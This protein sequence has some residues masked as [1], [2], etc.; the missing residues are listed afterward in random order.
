MAKSGNWDHFRRHASRHVIRFSPCFQ[1]LFDFCEFIE[2]ANR[3]H[4]PLTKFEPGCLGATFSVC[5]QINPLKNDPLLDAIGVGTRILLNGAEGF[6]LSK[7]TRCSSERPNLAG[8]SDMHEM[9]P[10]YIGRFQDLSR[11]WMYLFLGS[12][13][14][15]Y[16]SHDT[17]R[18][19]RLDKRFHYQFW[20][21]FL[22][23]AWWQRIMSGLGRSRPESGFLFEG[24]LEMC[25]LPGRGPVP[26][27]EH[28]VHKESLGKEMNISA[29]IVA[30]VLLNVLVEPSAVIWV[31]FMYLIEKSP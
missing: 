4:F 14:P 3:Y 28:W 1:K 7:G 26:P 24:L 5:G 17:Q 25:M 11:S 19:G 27:W 10:E 15:R 21:W 23:N 9:E 8:F 20:M 2:R 22:G 18:I 31:P 6:V 13:Y 29:S 30:S 12:S 16:Q